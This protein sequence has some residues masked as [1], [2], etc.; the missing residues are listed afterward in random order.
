[1]RPRICRAAVVGVVGVLAAGAG[2]PTSF[3]LDA[4]AV[5]LPQDA[6]HYKVGDNW[7]FE[8]SDPLSGKGR[9]FT[10]TVTSATPM[11]AHRF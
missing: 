1:M 6:P 2:A 4:A 3:A 10:Q 5:V 8:R 7:T 9:T 11:A